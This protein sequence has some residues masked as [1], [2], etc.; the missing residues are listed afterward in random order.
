MTEP[1]FAWLEI[2][3]KCQL[4]CEHCYADSGPNGTHGTM[5]EADWRRVIDEPTAQGVAMVQFI[6]GEP[7][8]HPA[9]ARPSEAQLCGNCA[10]GVAAISA[11]GWVWPCVFARWL[12]V[13]NVLGASVAEIWNGATMTATANRLAERFAADRP[14]VPDM[15]DPQCG[16]SCSPACMPSRN[17]R[18]TQT[19]APN[20]SCGP[21]VP[22]DR[23]CGPDRNCRPNQCRPT[24]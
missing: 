8:T 14:C 21:C 18:P 9:F 6:G 1:T 22:K 3:G 17:C 11:D 5:D 7:T 12:P 24:R 10:Q 23:T 4:A 13:G 16:P 2:T 20:Y 19:C 15:C